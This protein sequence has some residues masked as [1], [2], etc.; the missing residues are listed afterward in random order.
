M[1]VVVGAIIWGGI[2]GGGERTTLSL[3][4]TLK[5]EQSENV[6]STHSESAITRE[7]ISIVHNTWV[8]SAH[9]SL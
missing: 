6:I 7:D 2:G 1:I 3:T 9:L 8:R 4:H 5:F